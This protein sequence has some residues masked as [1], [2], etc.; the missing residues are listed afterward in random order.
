MA[1]TKSMLADWRNNT[2]TQTLMLELQ[3]TMENYV[4]ELVRDNPE[5][6]YDRDNWIRA[7]IALAKDVIA[8]SPEIVDEEDF[9]EVE[10]VEE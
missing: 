6:S 10:D 7:Y 4:A 1:V 3:E 8:F 5:R 2:V 9:Q